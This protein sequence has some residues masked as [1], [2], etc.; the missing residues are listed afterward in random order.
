METFAK[1]EKDVVVSDLFF[2]VYKNFNIY[3]QSERMK[4]LT[5]I[6]LYLILSCVC[7][8]HEDDSIVIESLSNFEKELSN[9]IDFEKSG[10]TDV[11]PLISI[12]N[13]FKS[14]IDSQ[15]GGVIYSKIVDKDGN[16]LPDPYKKDEARDIKMSILMNSYRDV[17]K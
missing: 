11:E 4:S 8:K 17:K 12:S 16:K 6:E 10:Q 1:E 15:F 3:D 9:F 7:E 2:D 5:E 14:V 13:M